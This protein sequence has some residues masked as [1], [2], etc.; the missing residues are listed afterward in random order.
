V[1]LVEGATRQS[2]AEARD[3]RCRQSVR[4]GW[5]ISLNG[6][7]GLVIIALSLLNMCYRRSPMQAESLFYSVLS[8]K[9]WI[10]VHQQQRNN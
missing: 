3:A 5:S 8:K 9:R 2:G 6:R 7:L 4:A 1:D 10:S